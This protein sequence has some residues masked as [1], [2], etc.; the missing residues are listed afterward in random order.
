MIAELESGIINYGVPVEE[1]VDEPEEV[2]V[3]EPLPKQKPLEV[4]LR[5]H[6]VKLIDGGFERK[7]VQINVGETVMWSNVRKA[8][9]NIALLVGNRECRDIKSGFF[10]TGESYNWTFNETGTCFVSDGIFTT[11]AMKVIVS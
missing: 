5:T 11:Q 7:T 4:G 9:Y 3:Q 8:Q 1:L 10:N 6:V 2:E